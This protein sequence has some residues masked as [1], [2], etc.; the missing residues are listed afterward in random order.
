VIVQSRGVLWEASLDQA[1]ERA[2][3]EGKALLLD[4]R[5]APPS[6]VCLAMDTGTYLH[7][8]VMAFLRRYFVPVRVVRAQQPGTVGWAPAIVVGDGERGPH[9]RVDGFESPA[10][11]IAQLGLGLGRYRFDRHEFAAAI[12]HF[13][14]VADRHEGTQAA[15]QA[16]FWLGIARFKQSTESARPPSS[17]A[18]LRRED[19]L[20]R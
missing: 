20:A 13:E 19:F 18:E 12:G 16:L 11:F 10:D 1:R 9:Y 4:F 7:P 17:G 8:E 5:T 14:E 6:P 2:R 3:R 15:A